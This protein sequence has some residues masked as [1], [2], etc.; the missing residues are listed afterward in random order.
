[1]RR[2]VS[3][4]TSVKPRWRPWSS[5]AHCKPL[6]IRMRDDA[7]SRSDHRTAQ[8]SERRAPVV[9][10]SSNGTSMSVPRDCS[11]MP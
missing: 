4:L 2:A 11:K 7:R 3:L 5:V 8:T 9:A 10:A 1:M 6:M